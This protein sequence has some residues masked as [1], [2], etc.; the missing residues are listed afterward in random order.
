MEGIKGQNQTKRVVCLELN[1]TLS[2]ASTGTS[3]EV[4][5]ETKVKLHDDTVI[6]EFGAPNAE[7]TANN[8]DGAATFQ[9]EQAS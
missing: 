2:G 6:D 7:T 3:R 4:D 1:S 8:S 9:E 5:R